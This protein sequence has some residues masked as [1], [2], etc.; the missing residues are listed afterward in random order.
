MS[1]RATIL[2]AAATA[3]GCS[4]PVVDDVADAS[5]GMTQA[6]VVVEHGLAQARAGSNGSSGSDGANA[7][8]QTSVSAKFMRLTA[9]VDPELAERVVGSRLDLPALGVCRVEAQPSQDLLPSA[10]SRSARGTIELID[11][12]D[13]T[14]RARDA[15]EAQTAQAAPAT[16]MSLAVRA[17]PEVGDL[18]S[19]M[20]YTSPDT[21]SD[22]PA[23]AIYTLEGSGAGLV[24]HFAIDVDA[25]AALDDVRVGGVA[26]A[27]G[28]AIDEAGPLALRWRA[29]DGPRV[30]GDMI[31]VDVSGVGG[32]TTRC[33]FEDDGAATLPAWVVARAPA[34][35]LMTVHRL[36]ERA[37]ASPGIDAGE[38]RFDLSIAGHIVVGH[39]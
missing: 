10:A 39:Q 6:V 35:G 38:V 24:D 9:P 20:F 34:N 37:F 5:G 17:F 3:I 22:L 2:I 4:A 14:L 29:A 33:S 1:L 12:G 15:N 25:P 16:R 30:A 8:S 26:L 27:D 19:G 21:S 28:V 11:V 23:G 31:Y 36:R 7:A 18:V 13:L 32:A